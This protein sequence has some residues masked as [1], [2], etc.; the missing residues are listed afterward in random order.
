[1]VIR[2]FQPGQRVLGNQGRSL[3]SVAGE[4]QKHKLKQELLAS[5]QRCLIIN[6]FLQEIL[7]LT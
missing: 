7:F 3:R 1:M 5:W 2:V 6:R 4:M